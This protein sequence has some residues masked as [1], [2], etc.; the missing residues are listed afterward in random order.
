MVSFFSCIQSDVV[1]VH[2]VIHFKS[3][4]F[5]EMVEEY[6]VR[7]H[8]LKETNIMAVAAKSRNCL[9]LKKCGFNLLILNIVFFLVLFRCINYPLAAKYT[10]RNLTA[11]NLQR[12][13][14][15]KMFASQCKS[16][17]LILVLQC[18]SHLLMLVLQ[19]K[20]V[21]CKTRNHPQPANPPT[22]YP[23]HP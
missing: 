8:K 18:K 15:Q 3:L 17:H 14:H 10:S 13:C 23:N 11:S 9:H 22:N 4:Q 16:H 6:L 2:N 1:V 5:P 21:R 12:K 19:Y 20:F 7:L